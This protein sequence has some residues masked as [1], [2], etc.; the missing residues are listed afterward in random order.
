MS[1][2]ARP[3]SP[4]P[5]MAA[6]A[7]TISRSI[8]PRRRLAG[9][10]AIGAD[11]LAT[12]DLSF[13][14]TNLDDLSPLMLTRMSGALQ[15]KVSASAADGRQAVAIVASSEKMAFGANRLEGL[16]V[17]LNVDDLWG[18]RSVSGL[19]RL[20]RAEVAG[21]SVSD[22]RLTA[23]GRGDF[24]DIDFTGSVFGFALASH[25]RLSGG[26][27]IRLDLA[28]F[29]ARRAGRTIALAG[30]AHADLWRRRNRHQELSRC[31][32]I[33]AACRSPAG[34]GPRSISGQARARCR[35]PRS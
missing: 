3:I 29:T 15:A 10:V 31:G 32:S 16:K 18:A 8:S 34:P 33:P 4:R 26:P 6:G 20:T 2:K 27:P 17:D 11:Q 21:Q 35:S 30:P 13:S 19:A 14:A 9:N 5:P 25:G 28:T 1:C 24:S 7:P 22:V 12:G 23:T